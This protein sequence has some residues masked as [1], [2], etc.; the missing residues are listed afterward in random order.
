MNDSFQKVDNVIDSIEELKIF[1]TIFELKSIRKAADA[2][3]LTSAAVSKRLI[4][5]ENRLSSKLFY[6]TTRTLSPTH[7]GEKLYNHTQKLLSITEEI[8]HDLDPTNTLKG[9]IKITASASF[10]QSFLLSVISGFLEKYPQINIEIISSDSLVDLTEQGIDLAIRHGPSRDSSLVG[11]KLLDSKRF[12]CASPSYFI[13]HGTPKSP[14]DLRQH[15]IL[16]VGQEGN[17]HFL[18][19]G[20]R[21]TIKL[22]PIFSSTL[23]DSVLGMAESGHGIALLSDWHIR[24]SVLNGQL[25]IVLEDWES[26]PSI[27]INL[28]YPS[29]K[30]Q[31][32]VVK[33][34]I[35]YL[36]ER[37][38]D[39]SL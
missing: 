20:E 35:N 8:E 26:D 21:T 31:S 1:S 9:K 24:N 22:T 14:I 17:W 11:Q 18:K 7:T 29:R 27:S 38:A 10:T 2:H 16:T 36:K 12:L 4:A 19:G 13:Q 30:N 34:F 39:S 33:S 23:G 28:L 6:R 3:S 5:L 15:K 32:M 37:L 25:K